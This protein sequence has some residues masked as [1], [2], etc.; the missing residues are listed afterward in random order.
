MVEEIKV[1]SL[2]IE[3]SKSPDNRHVH[4][5]ESFGQRRMYAA[6]LHTI[7]VIENIAD[8]EGTIKQDCAREIQAGRCCAENLREAEFGAGKAIFFKA[9]EPSTVSVE[10]QVDKYSKS[11][12]RGFNQPT[13]KIKP[14][15]LPPEYKGAKPGVAKPTQ[16]AKS[17]LKQKPKSDEF[18][19]IDY[20]KM[21]IDMAAE[22]RVEPQRKDV[23]TKKE[24]PLDIAKRIA[25]KRGE[26][27]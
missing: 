3:A 8:C 1:K 15:A 10:Y 6:C 12:M 16:V 23:E 17:I 22:A 27:L 25:K 2:S 4:W 14:I 18:E 19:N 21:V 5:C 13:G 7:G 11:Y 24:S 26:N 9:K 20:G